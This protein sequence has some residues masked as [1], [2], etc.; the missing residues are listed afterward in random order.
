MSAQLQQH[1]WTQLLQEQKPAPAAS[2]PPTRWPR[3]WAP[4]SLAPPGQPAGAAL[5][6]IVL[7]CL[8][9]RR[10]C[11]CRCRCR[12]K[13]RQPTGRLADQPTSRPDKRE[14]ERP[15]PLERACCGLLPFGR[16]RALRAAFALK[17]ERFLSSFGLDSQAAPSKGKR[18]EFKLSL[19]PLW[20]RRAPNCLRRRMPRSVLFTSVHF[21]SVQL[22][23]IF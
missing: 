23:A 6:P 21:S 20:R 13:S 1:G 4:L 10:Y 2:Y 5:K 3:I 17:L 9:L 14:R 16:P 15:R 11:R 12:P 8:G 19:L 22:W 18:R 7:V